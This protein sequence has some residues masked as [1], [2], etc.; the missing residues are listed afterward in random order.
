M[1]SV[2]KLNSISL[3]MDKPKSFLFRILEIPYL[4]FLQKA[5]TNSLDLKFSDKEHVDSGFKL[6]CV[7]TVFQEN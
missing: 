5:S 6:I 3:Y 4:V 1:R 2:Q 7:H